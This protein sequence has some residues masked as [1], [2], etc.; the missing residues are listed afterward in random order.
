MSRKHAILFLVLLP[1]A[2]SSGDG[3]D[4]GPFRADLPSG[5]CKVSVFDDAGRGVVGARVVLRGTNLNAITGRNGRCDFRSNAAGQVVVTVD[6]ANAAASDSDDLGRLT[7][8]AALQSR[9]FPF[10]VHLPD[11]RA[12]SGLNL[13]VGTQVAAST[14]D[15]LASTGARI[16]IPAGGSVGMPT[17]VTDL[18]FRSGPLQPQHLPGEL[19]SH[20][21]SAW[22]L[23]RGIYLDPPEVTF[24]PP[25]DLEATDDLLL[26]GLTAT[27][28][29]LDQETGTWQVVAD[30]LASQAG[31]LRAPGVLAR[32]GLYAFGCLVT[33]GAVTGRVVDTAS[34]ARPLQGMQVL[35]DG[36]VVTTGSNGVFT[37]AGV[38]A[39]FGVGTRRSAQIAVHTDGFWM[40]ATTVTSMAMNGSTT[41]DVGDLVLD[42]LPATTIYMQMVRRGRADGLRACTVSSLFGGVAQATLADSNGQAV[43]EDL[44]SRW[45]GFQSG[46][47]LDRNLINYAQG[48]AFVPDGRRWQNATQFVD[49][50]Q[51]GNSPRTLRLLAVDPVGG[52]PLQSVAFVRGRSP[53]AGLLGTTR[54]GGATFAGRDVGGR[55]TASLESR[56]G[57]D[58][59][60]HALSIERPGGQVV[61]FPLERPR[62]AELGA[63]D[64][65]G[66]LVGRLTAVDPARQHG[67]RA[68]RR[69]ELHEWWQ[70]VVAGGQSIS[71]LPVDTDPALT[72]GDF[73]IGVAAGVGHV[74][75]IET[76][77]VG[78]LA[79][80]EKLGLLPDLVAIDGGASAADVALD[81]NASA[82]FAAP[83]LLAGLDPAIPVADLRLDLALQQASGLGIDVARGLAR[84]HAASGPDLEL[85]LPGL[86][87]RLAGFRWWGYLAGGAS[88]SGFEIRQGVLLRFRPPPVQAAFL[89]VPEISVPAPGAL[90]DPTGFTVEFGLPP[91]TLYGVLELRSHGAGETLI[92]EAYVPPTASSFAF[93]RLPTQAATPLRSAK[94]YTLR[95]SAFGSRSGVLVGAGQAYQKSTS[96]LQ[97]IGA[98]ERGV[99]CFSSRSFL[100]QTN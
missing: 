7:V 80:L 46:Y 64:R 32:G 79:R 29:H 95:L 24:F 87:D 93:V 56:S 21:T 37:L 100:I 84:N 13:T 61:E 39:T 40:P 96:N 34:P 23:G 4:I 48:V 50:R 17:A 42:T 74:V 8:A 63:F 31:L 45:F 75:G 58:V 92:W 1:G 71:R 66:V 52:G 72:H 54:E 43:F 73:R 53:G 16:S 41:V 62:R 82:V 88:S 83:G 3:S 33:A 47:P 77:D 91:G 19:P 2:C 30:G 12:S 65:H 18:Q 27:L 11:L 5:S 99:D 9:D 55:L 68:T 78:G 26:G 15:D 36:R 60:V 69:F 35:V 14:L 57:A 38:A 70:E 85:T 25:V 94:T 6:G 20:P 28:F 86:T 81:Q 76:S 44:P 49:R 59:L 10:P 90:V 67:I 22:L 98:V 97:S 51:W 89:P